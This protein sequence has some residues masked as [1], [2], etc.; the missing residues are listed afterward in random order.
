[1]KKIIYIVLFSILLNDKLPND[2]RWVRNSSEYKSLCHQVYSQ[3]IYKLEK[4]IKHNKFSL[5]TRQNNYAV[6]MDLDE[7]VLDNS[8]YQVDLFDKNQTFN[9]DSWAT[10]V[11][12]EEAKLVPGA[13]KYI[14]HL[15]KNNIQIIFISNRMHARLKST[16]NNMKKLGIFSE[17]D[18]YLLRKDK[19]DKK[20]IRRNEV[21]SATGRMNEFD[22]FTVIQ[23][24]G[25][26]MGDFNSKKHDRFGVDQF[27]LPNPMYGKW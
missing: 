16:K 23:Y 9:M 1:M 20:Q 22:E 4:K 5:N 12:K 3:A 18:I 17:Y 11:E 6:I 24:L 25:D 7:T 19:S 14:N 27:I 10:W 26:A 21:F 15:R 13:Q 2:V 8:D